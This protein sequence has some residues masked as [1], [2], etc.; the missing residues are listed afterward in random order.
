MKYEWDESK[1]EINRLKH[2]ID[3][4]AILDFEWDTAFEVQD[5]RKEYQEKRWIALGRIKSRLHVLIYVIRSNSIRII[6]LRKANK[7]EIQYYEKA[8]SHFKS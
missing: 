5:D 1:R 7:R 6:S 3:F 2:D 8:P 4:P